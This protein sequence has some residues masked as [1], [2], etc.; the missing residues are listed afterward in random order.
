MKKDKALIIIDVQKDFCTG[1]A[2]PVPNG[3][4]IIPVLNKYISLFKKNRFPIVA[5]R[6]W[7]PEDSKHFKSNGG[8]WPKHCVVKSDGAKFHPKLCLPASAKI[9]SK[10]TIP[11]EDG[12]SA[13]DARDNNKKK[14]SRIIKSIG[15]K[16]IFIGG[17]ATD[18]CVKASALSAIK[19]NFKVYLLKDAVKGISS[20]ASADAIS[21]MREKGIELLDFRKASKLFAGRVKYTRKEA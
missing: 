5:S 7:H 8:V 16:E 12:Y 11:S 4:R 3:E 13:F 19:E 2:L 1:G 6:D 18:Y 9:V 17:L 14:L 21:L 10:G 15:V 20:K